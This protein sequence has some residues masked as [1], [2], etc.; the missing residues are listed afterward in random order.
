MNTKRAI[1]L[2]GLFV[3]L[4]LAVSVWAYPQVPDQMATHWNAAGQVDGTM[5]KL[6]GLFLVPALAA[7]TVAVFV[8]LPKIDPR[9]ENYAPF[10]R[11]YN[12]FIVVMAAF[13]AII[14]TAS[15]A[16]NLGYAIDMT[17]TSV[18]SM[19]LLL[20]YLG[21]LLDHAEPNWFVGIRTPWTLSSDTVWHATHHLGSRL[22]KLSGLLALFGVFF[23]NY[24]LSL[25][26]VPTLGTA[27]VTFVYSFVKY[28]QLGSGGA[29]GG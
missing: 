25:L 29:I 23:P 22:F 11:Y 6:W 8:V 18:A 5:P 12:G 19:G 24:A 14:H 15:V 2:S 27:I 21:V 16:Y 7:G 10:R 26:L 3:A 1:V 9:R 28:R 13:L 17:A 20:F 4:S